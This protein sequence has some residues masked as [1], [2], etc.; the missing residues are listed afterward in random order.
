MFRAILISAILV[1]FSTQVNAGVEVSKTRTKRGFIATM[2]NAEATTGVC[3]DGAGDLM[4][5]VDGFSVLTFE[6]T[7]SGAGTTC[8][9]YGQVNTTDLTGDA[10]LSDNFTTP[11][12]G[13]AMSSSL[14]KITI[15]D[16]DFKYVWIECTISGGSAATV[17]MR[18]GN[19]VADVRFFR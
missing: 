15:T 3:D 11:I 10:D 18:A 5:D 19:P 8:D 4:A 17:V 9:I 6:F 2:C 12:N 1:L 16:A 13:T 7:Q 14:E